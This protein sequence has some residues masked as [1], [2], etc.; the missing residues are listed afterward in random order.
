MG[1]PYLELTTKDCHKLLQKHPQEWTLCLGAGI[2]NKVL[3][4]W[5]ELT[6][7]VINKVFKFG[8]DKLTF[9][10]TN[11]S[12]GFSYDSWI[13]ACLNRHVEEGNQVDSFHK[14][15]ENEIYG[16][17]ILKAE[18]EGIKDLMLKFLNKPQMRRRP[19]KKVTDFFEK[20]YANTTL[21][22]LV[23][24][25]TSDDNTFRLPDKI[26]TFNADTLLYSLIVAYS[27]IKY[28][29]L[30]NP[31]AIEPYKLILKS[32]HSWGNK[33]P[34]LHLHGS[35]Y[36]ELIL[37][38]TKR[39][40]KQDG[41]DNLIFLESSYTKV[42]GSMYTWAQ[43][44]FLYYALNTKIV[45]LGLSMSDPNIRKWL[46]WTNENIN[47][48]LTSFQK[49][50][51]NSNKHIWLKPKPSS[52]ETQDFLQSSLTHLGVKMGWIDNYGQVKSSLLNIM[53]R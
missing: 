51:I 35:I 37:H 48:D 53:E 5:S 44:N 29:T 18:S 49:T 34:I 27:E 2:N 33:I 45:F 10:K 50:D 14:I 7:N 42:A 23:D 22:Q 30:K 47:A 24:V 32:Y 25:L 38:K 20:H 1:K 17:L 8:W 3:P 6:L 31:K 36:P 4:D 9:E 13:Q 40:K 19:Q 12:I 43:T 11:K 39:P 21:M 52:K 41:R 15:L 28:S 16:D 26:I 46:N